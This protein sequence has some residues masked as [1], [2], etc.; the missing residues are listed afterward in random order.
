MTELW[1]YALLGLAVFAGIKILNA[2]GGNGGTLL[3]E[4]D[5]LTLALGDPEETL[6]VAVHGQSIPVKI[7]G[8]TLYSQGGAF[9]TTVSYPEIA[10]AAEMI[11]TSPAFA[12]ATA[13]G[14]EL[15]AQYYTPAHLMEAFPGIGPYLKGS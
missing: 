14:G 6:P 5:G 8:E 3:P 7:N 11:T 13:P 1:K 15:L 9:F 4:R 12:G 2:Q 10:A